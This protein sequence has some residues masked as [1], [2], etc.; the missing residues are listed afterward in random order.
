MHLK[1]RWTFWGG[2]LVFDY[3]SEGKPSAHSGPL[4]AQRFF[5]SPPS[6]EL[7]TV[8]TEITGDHRSGK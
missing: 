4:E 5:M 7:R 8:G 3:I 6:G 1:R 2:L